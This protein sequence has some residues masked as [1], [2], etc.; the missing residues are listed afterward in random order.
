MYRK[1][2]LISTLLLC[3]AASA[4]AARVYW[5][6]GGTDHL[7][8]NAANWGSYTD[9]DVNNPDGILTPVTNEPNATD[10]DVY[11]GQ[12]NFNSNYPPQ[13]YALALSGAMVDPTLDHISTAIGN[14]YFGGSTTSWSPDPNLDH[15]L[16]ITPSGQLHANGDCKFPI[17]Q[18][19]GTMTAYNEGEIFANNYHLTRSGDNC[20]STLY[21]YSGSYLMLN[22]QLL[23]PPNQNK[24]GRVARLYLDDTIV[25]CKRIEWGD[26]VASGK[27]DIA[28]GSKITVRQK[29]HNFGWEHAPEWIADGRITGHGGYA[30]GEVMT[31]TTPLIRCMI[32]TEEVAMP[33]DGNYVGKFGDAYTLS[34]DGG[35]DLEITSTTNDAYK[36]YDPDPADGAGT[37]GTPLDVFGG[38]SWL[39]GYDAVTHL[40]YYD[41]VDGSTYRATLGA[42]TETWDPLTA[43]VLI[44]DAN[45]YWRVDEVNSSG[46]TTV[47]DVWSFQVTA[48]PATDLS[49]RDDPETEDEDEGANLYPEQVL[50]WTAGTASTSSSVYMSTSWGD[51]NDRTAPVIYSGTDESYDLGPLE[52]NTRYYWCVDAVGTGTVAGEIVSFS[53]APYILVDDFE[54]YADGGALLGVWSD[55]SVGGS[56]VALLSTTESNSGG[57]SMKVYYDLYYTGYGEVDAPMSYRSDAYS[58]SVYVK[59]VAGNT[60]QP[61]YLGVYDGSSTTVQQ[62]ADVNSMVTDWTECRVSLAALGVTLEDIEKVVIGVGDRAGSS[63]NEYGDIYV[64]D[65]SLYPRRCF[66]AN[67]IAEDFSGNCVVDYDDLDLLSAGYLIAK[68]APTA[69][70][71][72]LSLY[73]PLDEGEGNTV[74]HDASGRGLDMDAISITWADSN[75]VNGT[76]AAFSHSAGSKFLADDDWH[77]GG[78]DDTAK[79]IFAPAAAV[80]KVTIMWYMKYR[81]DAVRNFV[82][83]TQIYNPITQALQDNCLTFRDVSGAGG[84]A[85]WLGRDIDPEDGASVTAELYY[86]PPYVDGYAG[87]SAVDP[88]ICDIWYH[89]AVVKDGPAET[90]RIYHDGVLVRELDDESVAYSIDNIC[91]FGFIGAANGYAWSACK[92]AWFDELRIYPDALREDEIKYLIGKSVPFFPEGAAPYDI[93][94]DADNIIN[95]KDYSDWAE[96]WMDDKLWP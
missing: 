82:Y 87:G 41:G 85:V 3:L 57:Q 2:L 86:D 55:D 67:V 21:C 10:G 28:N 95:L 66:A 35:D 44:L 38:L 14:A 23:C 5:T 52:L 89:I 19:G 22:V 30:N 50:T 54:S 51:V 46:G 81:S 58:I 90:A 27:V 79:Q 62:V 36:A 70:T 31:G 33:A 83:Q 11:V 45:S 16:W 68:T 34:G 93:Y 17:G 94:E 84:N 64:D 18:G 91:S 4:S 12:G 37:T 26:D 1:F 73:L 60:A 78:T 9:P 48:G 63:L 56:S 39:A 25:H 80:N 42:G 75:G 96:D 61:I 92:N 32:V 65:V 8:S 77:S 29:S 72:P 43:G 71:A 24:T 13:L 20:T 15:F 59:G 40:V 88:S 69:P 74:A 6:D 7:W 53:T 49:P 47:G 76:G